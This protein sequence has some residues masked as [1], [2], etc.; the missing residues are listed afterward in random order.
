MALFKSKQIAAKAPIPTAD[1]AV[2]V[3]PIFGD[4]DVPAGFASGDVV[5]MC[6]LPAGYVPVDLIVDN[7]AMG[8]TVT[9][10]V[11]IVTGL[12]DAALNLAGAARACGAEFMA[13]QDFQTAGIKRMAA[14][15]GGRVAPAYDA[16]NGVQYNRS[17]G[18]VASTVSVPTVGA[19]VRFTLLCRPAVNGV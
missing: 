17:V 6:P 3:I 12:Y 7:A 10:D 8:T 19:T 1:R 4:F 2:E 5:E 15:G 11:G 13:A 9:S 18:F 14:A 16:G